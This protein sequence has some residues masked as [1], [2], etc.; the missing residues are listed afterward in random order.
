MRS[1]KFLLWSY[2]WGRSWG[3][4]LQNNLLISQP[5]SLHVVKFLSLHVFG[6]VKALIEM[7]RVCDRTNLA[8]WHH[9][10]E[11][12][13]DG[14]L[15]VIAM[16]MPML[17]DEQTSETRYTRSGPHHGLL[18][19]T[20]CLAQSMNADEEIRIDFERIGLIK[21]VPWLEAS[22]CKKGV[23][24]EFVADHVCYEML[25]YNVACTNHKWLS[26]SSY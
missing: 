9:A 25:I 2:F 26:L 4:L 1:D 5:L 3:C 17:Y 20:H 18:I 7:S 19:F 21:L 13:G 12:Q 11:Y 15:D 16:P 22:Q 23:R 6:N 8:T 10:G 14:T 24:K